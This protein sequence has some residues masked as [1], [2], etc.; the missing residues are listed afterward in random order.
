MRGLRINP[1]GATD[2]IKLFRADW[3]LRGAILPAGDH[4]LVMRF[5]PAVYS[6]SE[7]VSRASSIALIVLLLLSFGGIY[8]AKKE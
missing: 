8:L 4:E 1:A 6:V 7:N 2:E 3:I 5:D